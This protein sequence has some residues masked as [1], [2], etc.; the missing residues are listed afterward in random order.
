MICIIHVSY[1]LTLCM[2]IS[3]P[4]HPLPPLYSPCGKKFRSKPQIAR[5]LGECA[6]LTAFDFSRGAMSGCGTSQRRARDR[7][8]RRVIDVVHKS[9]HVRPL[10]INPLGPSGPIRRTCGVIKLPVTWIPEPKREQVVVCTNPEPMDTSD[11]TNCVPLSNSHMDSTECPLPVN[12]SQNRSN[13]QEQTTTKSPI[14]LLPSPHPPSPS[15]PKATQNQNTPP[16]P[17]ST[18]ST[19]SSS[20][21]T[22]S[23]HYN[24]PVR[25]ENALRGYVVYDHSTKT[26]INVDIERLQG[27]NAQPNMSRVETNAGDKTVPPGGVKLPKGTR[28]AVENSNGVQALNSTNPLPASSLLSNLLGN[29]KSTTTSPC[30]I[31]PL[32]KNAIGNVTPSLLAHGIKAHQQQKLGGSGSQGT[33]SPSYPASTKFR[34]DNNHQAKTAA[35]VSAQPPNMI[36]SAGNTIFS[37]THGAIK[38]I[39]RTS[40]GNPVTRPVSTITPKQTMRT[41]AQGGTGGNLSTSAST[42]ANKQGLRV[43][44]S[45]V[46]LQEARV[47]QLREKLLAAQGTV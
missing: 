36:L 40:T 28:S 44:E 43:S 27:L 1:S 46:V 15:M 47:K 32:L 37:P 39:K 18:S 3:L 6:D 8:A 21:P 2:L 30:S 31:P 25:W 42:E 19:S 24:R 7:S 41:A 38:M 4:H 23:T 45:D 10:S 17:S 33:A 12:G 9:S 13:S 22:S 5:F 16:I 14:P 35:N 11:Q 20:S 34:K 29:H 26:E